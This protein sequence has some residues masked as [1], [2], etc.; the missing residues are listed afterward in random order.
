MRGL[1]HTMK[2]LAPKNFINILKKHQL[3]KTVAI[4]TG[5]FGKVVYKSRDFYKDSALNDIVEKMATAIP[6]AL[7]GG[8]R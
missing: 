8:L 3:E 7:D 6:L 5:D 1:N 4:L 2:L